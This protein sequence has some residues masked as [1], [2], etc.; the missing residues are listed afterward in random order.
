MNY[1]EEAYLPGLERDFEK[2]LEE[3]FDIQIQ[4][5]LKEPS[6]FEAWAFHFLEDPENYESPPRKVIPKIIRQMLINNH[7]EEYLDILE[8]KVDY[9]ENVFLSIYLSVFKKFDQ[10]KKDQ[11]FSENHRVDAIDI[12][13]NNPQADKKT[14]E[15]ISGVEKSLPNGDRD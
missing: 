9:L 10:N 11:K 8:K 15:F 1:K 5:Y 6:N 2:E 7:L 13:Q 14:I 4:E 3:K 12:S